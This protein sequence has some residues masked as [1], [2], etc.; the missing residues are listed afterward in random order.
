MVFR[1]SKILAL[2]SAWAPSLITAAARQPARDAPGSGGLPA[3]QFLKFVPNLM[4]EAGYYTTN[5]KGDYNIVGMKYDQQG[6]RGGD[7]PWRS[8]PDKSQPFFSKIDFGIP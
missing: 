1:Q 7:T 5:H 4:G 6:K 8:R 3:P 2:P